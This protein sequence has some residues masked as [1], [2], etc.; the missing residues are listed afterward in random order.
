MKQIPFFLFVLFLLSCKGQNS[1]GH[2]VQTNEITQTISDG[3]PRPK[4]MS[5]FSFL[6]VKQ[7]PAY[8][9]SLQVSDYI[10]CMLE[11]KNGNIW[12]G[13][14]NE[15]VCRYDGK[16]FVYFTTKEGISGNAVRKL[17]EDKEGN[18]WMATN[19][20]LTMYNGKTFR[21]FTE[22][23]GL[24]SNDT[25]SMLY[26]SKGEIWAGTMKGVCKLNGNRFTTIELPVRSK[27]KCLSRFTSQLVWTMYEDKQGNTWFG[28]DGD[29][30]KKFDGKTISNYTEA[31]GLAGNNVLSITEDKTGRLWFGTWGKGVSCYDQKTFKNYNNTNG[32][33]GNDVWSMLIDDKGYL[34]MGT[35]GKGISRFN[36]SAFTTY[37]EKEGFTRN[38]VQSIMQTKNGEMWFGFSGGVFLLKDSQLIN[39]IK[40]GC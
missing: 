17:V 35:L 25:W 9:P 32:L 22:K 5:V 24:P 36:G 39:F 30:V 12:F 29:G 4:Q 10:R 15:G 3:Q 6:S 18:I 40:G 14:N 33:A 7:K 26:N 1:S 16:Q 21:V 28:T 11:D 31:D 13:T 19:N 2:T 38:H 27:S 23:D 37:T 34:W 8:D 20:G